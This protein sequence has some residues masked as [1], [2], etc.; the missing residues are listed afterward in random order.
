G[1]NLHPSQLVRF[2]GVTL[3]LT[4]SLFRDNQFLDPGQIG[5][6]GGRR[7]LSENLTGQLLQGVDQAHGTRIMPVFNASPPARTGSP[8]PASPRPSRGLRCPLGSGAAH[9]RRPASGEWPMLEA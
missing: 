7:I 3:R 2:G 6:L 1:Q 8:A 9:G 4:L 5:R